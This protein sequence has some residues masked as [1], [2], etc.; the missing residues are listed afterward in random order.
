MSFLYRETQAVTGADFTHYQRPVKTS[1]YVQNGYGSWIFWLCTIFKLHTQ[2]TAH[3]KYQWWRVWGDTVSCRCTW[4]WHGSICWQFSGIV[5]RAP[6]ELRENRICVYNNLWFLWSVC[7]IMCPLHTI[8]RKKTV[9]GSRPSGVSWVVSV[10]V[11]TFE[12]S[13]K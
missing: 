4:S 8:Q 3:E 7:I 12:N 5:S 10:R 1:K 6:H 9:V 13:M 2:I 11:N